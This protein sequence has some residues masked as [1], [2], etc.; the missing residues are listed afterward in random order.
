LEVVIWYDQVRNYNL[1]V[2]AR[3]NSLRK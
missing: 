3:E 2:S 1:Q